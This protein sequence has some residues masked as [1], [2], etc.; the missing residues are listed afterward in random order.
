[1]KIVSLVPSLTKTICDLG[2]R[3]QIAA[4]TNFCVDPPDLYR[5]VQRVGGTKDPNLDLLTLIA[6]TH[7]LANEEENRAA[8]LDYIKSQFN[9]L[10]TFPKSPENVPELLISMGRFLGKTYE[11][12]RLADRVQESIDSAKLNCILSQNLGQNFIYLIWRD[13]WMAAG[14]DT[15]ISRF[16]ELLGFHNV[17]DLPARYPIVDHKSL[18]RES[19][20]I[21]FL[22][23]EPWPFRKR[24]ADFLRKE[25]GHSCPKLC[26]ID[27]KAFSWY[28]ST[29]LE[30][31]EAIKGN[32]EV[33][34]TK[35]I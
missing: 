8:D 34:L 29:T 7:V 23:S 19:V 4:I 13:P 33:G 18:S 3:D 22:S 28:G 10:V 11:A 16:L 17:I 15:Y 30:A 35:D 27:G 24:D 2:L 1:M 14:R 21:V 6:P 20:D 32:Q 31:L 25:L 12:Q 5:Q 26:W 9:T